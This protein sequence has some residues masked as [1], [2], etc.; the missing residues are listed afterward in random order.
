MWLPL[1]YT[2]HRNTTSHKIR[3]GALDNLRVAA[4]DSQTVSEGR[5]GV[6]FPWR[7]VAEAESSGAL[8]DFSATC[9][10][11]GEALTELLGD[12]VVPIGLVATAIGG[13]MIEEWVTQV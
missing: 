9:L 12:G 1:K 5:G 2:Y 4:G 13:S 8:A 6:Q 10:Y 11:F 3:T 7:H